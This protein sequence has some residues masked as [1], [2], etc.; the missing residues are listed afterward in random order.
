[1]IQISP[2]IDIEQ[3]LPILWEHDLKNQRI[4]FP[5]DSPRRQLFEERIRREYTEEPDGFFFIIEVDKIV[6]SLILKT[7][8][9]HYRGKRYGDVRAIYLDEDKR[10]QGHGSR[11]L[12]FAD[13]HFKSKGC[14][15]VFAGISAQNPASNSL[16]TGSGYS[17]TRVILEKEYEQ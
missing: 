16:F 2:V 8:I 17:Q 9:N 6:G 4:N 13:D 14:S 3:A 7:K 12:Q 10:G 5:K 11:M 1:M 15:Y